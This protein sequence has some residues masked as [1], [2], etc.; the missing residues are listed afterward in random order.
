MKFRRGFVSN[1]SSSS[2]VC[3][4][5]GDTESGWDLCLSE[6]EMFN[7]ENG[8]TVHKDCCSE[9]SSVEKFLENAEEEEIEDPKNPGEYIENPDF[10]EES[11]YN[12]PAK[13][14]PIC[15]FE[16]I[17]KDDALQFILNKL[18]ISKEEIDKEIKEKFMGKPFKEFTEAV[19]QK[20]DFK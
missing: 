8:H 1:S 20:V 16:E 7:C 4:V 14:C 12:V 15:S 5:C 6:A 11:I 2:F 18:G 10:N 17:T 3:D 13:Y 9:N 19:F